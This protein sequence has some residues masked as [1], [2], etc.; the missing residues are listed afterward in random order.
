[1]VT[2]GSARSQQR[3]YHGDVETVREANLEDPHRKIHDGAR[4][5]VRA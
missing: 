1:V 3:R 5:V 2:A 4:A